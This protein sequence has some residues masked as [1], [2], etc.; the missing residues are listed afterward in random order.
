MVPFEVMRALRHWLCC[1]GSDQGHSSGTG[2]WVPSAEKLAG[3]DDKGSFAKVLT[4]RRRRCFRRLCGFC[5][6]SHGWINT[7]L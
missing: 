1:H 4:I 7:A 6:C 5:D 2:R 3:F